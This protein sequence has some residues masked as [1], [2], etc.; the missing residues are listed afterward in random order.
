MSVD[1]T[2]RGGLRMHMAVMTLMDVFQM[3]IVQTAASEDEQWL[4]DHF[5]SSFNSI[6]KFNRMCLRCVF[7]IL[8]CLPSGSIFDIHTEFITH[9]DVFGILTVRVTTSRIFRMPIVFITH[10]DMFAIDIV[11]PSIYEGSIRPLSKSTF[12]AICEKRCPRVG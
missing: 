12:S 11:R 8:W 4:A 5:T 3:Y 10:R 2:T 6:Q 1:R 7:D 9:P